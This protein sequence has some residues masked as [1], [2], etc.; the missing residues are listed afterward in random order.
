MSDLEPL[1]HLLTQGLELLF[2]HLCV[3]HLHMLTAVWTLVV[4]ATFRFS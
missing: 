4:L 2:S 3:S 1:T